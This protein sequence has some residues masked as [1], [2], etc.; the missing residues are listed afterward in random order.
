MSVAFLGCGL[1]GA[2]FVKGL[3]GKKIAVN[4]WNRSHEKAK[5]PAAP[6]L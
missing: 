1:M 6:A 3:L 5:V 2:G 4:V